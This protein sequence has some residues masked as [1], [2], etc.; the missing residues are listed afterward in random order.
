MPRLARAPL[1][2]SARALF[3]A[4]TSRAAEPAGC[5]RTWSTSRRAPRHGSPSG[6]ER[7]SGD[8]A[9]HGELDR[10]RGPG[11]AAVPLLAR[12]GGCLSSGR[13]FLRGRD[14]TVRQSEVRPEA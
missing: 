6:G 8:A 5:P 4:A 3:P 1:V 7:G 11:I 2:R 14:Q 10:G 9:L 12:Y 13:P